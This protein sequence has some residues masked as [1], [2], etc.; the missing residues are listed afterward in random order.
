MSRHFWETL[1]KEECEK[2]WMRM[3]HGAIITFRGKVVAM[4]YNQPLPS[5]YTCQNKYSVHAEVNVIKKFLSCYPKSMLKDCVLVVIRLNRE[6]K[7]CNSMP[8]KPCQN[9]I[10]KFAVRKVFYS[11]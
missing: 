2:S 7:I 8:C 11:V 10:S 6:H 9:Y 3:R 1:C 5:N 4:S